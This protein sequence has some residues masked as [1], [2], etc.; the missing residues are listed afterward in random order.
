MHQ[1]LL[2]TRS[3]QYTEATKQDIPRRRNE[4]IAHFSDENEQVF[5]LYIKFLYNPA[6]IPEY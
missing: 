4:R 6:G 2:D 3:T 1:S 5:A